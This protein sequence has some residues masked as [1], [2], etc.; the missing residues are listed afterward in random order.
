[1]P[2]TACERPS[3]TDPS[4]PTNIELVKINVTNSLR[5]RNAP[6]GPTTVGWVY[7]DEIVTRLVKGTEKVGGTYWDYV[8]KS[9]GTK[10]YAAR[11]TYDTE[12]T[13]KLYLVPIE[14]E[15]PAEPEVPDKPSDSGTTTIIKNDKVKIDTV[16]NEVTTV[17]NATVKDFSDLIGKDVVVKN[18][19]GEILTSDA[20]LSTGCVIDDIYMVVVLGDV[21]GDG[22]I[23]TGDTYF[24]KLVVL[25]QKVLDKQFAKK[26]S[27]VNQDGEIDTGDTYLLK[28]QVLSLSNI[29]L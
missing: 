20:K 12:S 16:S 17:P 3:T 6:N 25:G 2:S 4:I 5:L 15:K 1:M 7:K 27:D 28:K 8:M 21:N 10:G 24:L 18:T 11:E 22:E 26:A 29:N 9:D 13:Y 14:T 23:D 19:K